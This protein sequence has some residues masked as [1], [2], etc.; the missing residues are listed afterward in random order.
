GAV[1]SHGPR[2]VLQLVA[3]AQSLLRGRAG[4]VSQNFERRRVGT[5][6]R[7]CIGVERRAE[8]EQRLHCLILGAQRGTALGPRQDVMYE[9]PQ[10]KRDRAC[11]RA[12]D[13]KKGGKAALLGRLLRLRAGC[14][15]QVSAAV[16]ADFSGLIDR[17]LAFAAGVHAGGVAQASGAWPRI[18]SDRTAFEGA[19]PAGS[20][21]TANWSTQRSPSSWCFRA[22]SVAGALSVAGRLQTEG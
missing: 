1:R 7:A 11:Q 21:G 14:D 5:A 18:T 20:I 6:L 9:G 10:A 17:A 22:G 16:R 13:E 8:L 12:P 4:A 2:N 15:R 19:P 3:F